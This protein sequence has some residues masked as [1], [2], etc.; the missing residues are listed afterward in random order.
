MQANLFYLNQLSDIPAQ[1]SFSII[2][3]SKCQHTDTHPFHIPKR[4]GARRSGGS[5]SQ[6]I[7]HQQDMLSGKAFG[8]V[9]AEHA[10]HILP[11]LIRRFACLRL[12]M[13]FAHH[14]RSIQGKTGNRCNPPGYILALVVPAYPLFTH[15]H[16]RSRRSSGSDRLCRTRRT[17]PGSRLRQRSA[18]RVEF[19]SSCRPCRSCRNRQP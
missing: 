3:Y 8:T 11:P 13:P 4:I 7:I 10:V 14:R 2:R 19:R 16:G 1:G 12:R 15:R 18:Q 17:Q 5:G 9:K 6:H